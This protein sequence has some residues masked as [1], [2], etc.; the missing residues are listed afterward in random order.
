LDQGVVQVVLRALGVISLALALSGCETTAE[1][2]AELERHARHQKLS[3]RGV[4]VGRENP[5]VRVVSSTVV[6][7]S[8]G[9][10]VVVKLR[11]TSGRTLENAPIEI[12]VRDGHGGVL[13][14]NDQPGAEPSLARVSV[15]A[16]GVTTTWV[17][18]QVQT[19][20]APASASA[21]V[22]EA[23]RASGRAPRMT[24]SDVHLNEEGGEAGAAGSV[25]NESSVTQQDLIV[26][27]VARRGTK[28][29]AAGRATLA[30]VP[31]GAT[32]PFQLYFVGDPKGAR[33]EASAPATT[34]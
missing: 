33:I 15:L 12:T 32:V 28:T 20:G 1:R 27:A 7:S 18:D 5:S 11:N 34:F 16:A 23:G 9:T 3:L 22:G 30:E 21:L 25:R 2:S 13:F 31:V 14:K 6:H 4:S 10:A 8:V 24:V 29:L 17:D 19:T 26:Y